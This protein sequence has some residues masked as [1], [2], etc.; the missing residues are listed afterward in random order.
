M[1][2]W[3]Q[4]WGGTTCSFASSC[5]GRLTSTDTATSTSPSSLRA[6]PPCCVA[7]YPRCSSSRGACTIS[8]SASAPSSPSW[9]KQRAFSSLGG[10]QQSVATPQAARGRAR[11]PRRHFKN[12]SCLCLWCAFGGAAFHP[13]VHQTSF[14][15][16][17]RISG[18]S[19]GRL[20]RATR[21]A[22]RQGLT[23]QACPP[24]FGPL[25][26]VG[27]MRDVHCVRRGAVTAV[28]LGSASC[29]VAPLLEELFWRGFFFPSLTRS[30]STPLAVRLNP[31]TSSSR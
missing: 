31:A 10:E 28:A 6:T 1:R 4:R 9:N 16:F 30:M 3:R 11:L 27:S 24:P 20:Q 7:P 18:S 15:G 26:H 21:C 17:G 23:I 14:P 19:W 2:S 22:L 29:V 25:R 8:R 13:R 5:S 12:L